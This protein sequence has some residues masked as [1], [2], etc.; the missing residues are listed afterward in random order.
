MIQLEPRYVVLKL[1]DV[2]ALPTEDIKNLQDIIEKVILIRK[3]RG[4]DPTTPCLVV[5]ADWPEFHP[6]A[7]AIITRVNAENSVQ[8]EYDAH[9]LELFTG[10]DSISC[11]KPDASE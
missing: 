1:K 6:T 3:E 5:E 11:G 2:Y 8:A 9:Q 4:A 7:Q 10:P